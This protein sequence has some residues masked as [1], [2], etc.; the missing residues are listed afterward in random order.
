MLKNV[1]FDLD[2]TLARFYDRVD[3]LEI[4]HEKGFYKNLGVHQK[5]LEFFL[6]FAS[7]YGVENTYI[8][9]ACIDSPFCM[10]EKY[11]WIEENIPIQLPK[12][13]IILVPCGVPKTDFVPG[14][15]KSTD[16]L[17][18]DY[19]ENLKSWVE[20]G[21]TPVKAINPINNTTRTWT[22]YALLCD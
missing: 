14:G 4:M 7:I 6:E 18:D 15:V 5:M 2:G 13:N 16:L 11:E 19:G 9:S 3:C 20:A 21:G 1:V 10:S 12:E 8:I 17:F 22:G